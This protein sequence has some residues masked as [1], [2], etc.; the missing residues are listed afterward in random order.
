MV[1]ICDGWIAGGGGL[2]EDLNTSPGSRDGVP[3]EMVS[4]LMATNR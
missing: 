3:L 2:D 1:T 4:K